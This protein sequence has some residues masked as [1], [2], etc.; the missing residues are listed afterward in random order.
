MTNRTSAEGFTLVEVLIVLAVIGLLIGIASAM[1]VYALRTFQIGTA[2]A[3]LQRAARTLE[4]VIRSQSNIRNADALGSG[5]EKELR[6]DNQ[7]LYYGDISQ[8]RY[9]E[10]HAGVPIQV[11]LEFASPSA[12]QLA[13][14]IRLSSAT[15]TYTLRNTLMLNN[16]QPDHN[17]LVSSPV[18]LQN[19][20]LL[21][22]S[23]P[24][25]PENDD[26]EDVDLGDGDEADGD[27]EDEGGTPAIYIVTFDKSHS[28]ASTPSPGAK[29]VTY[30]SAYGEL[31]TVTRPGNNP[32]LGWYTQPSGGS[33]VTSDTIVAI[34]HHHTLYA[35]W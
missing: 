11:E 34:A 9:V 7:R 24:F 35:R 28:S 17:A 19:G 2:Q 12:R 31:P 14:T 18:S 10:V 23:F 21:Y 13:Y 20:T 6:L 29:H 22:E 16:V 5:S 26:E 27:D 32:F 1:Q 33:L 25:P 4:E 8:G 3:D 15:D 30:G